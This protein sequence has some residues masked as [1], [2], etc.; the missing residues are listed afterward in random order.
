MT[1]QDLTVL[2]VLMVKNESRIIERCL[3]AALP[4][5]DAV[6]LADTGSSDDTVAVAE[7]TVRAAQKPFH[8]VTNEWQD[9]GTNRTH[10]L[11][12]ARA[13]VRDLGWRLDA[14]YALVLDADMQFRGDPALLKQELRTQRLSGGMVQQRNG[15]LEYANMR[16]VLLSDGWFCEGVTHEYWT[17]GGAQWNVPPAVA[18]I[19]DVGD[20][21]A[22]ADKFERDERLLLAGLAKD[23]GCV[24]YM[25]YLAQTYHCMNRHLDAIHWYEKRIAAGSWVEEVWYSHLMIARTY[26]RLKEPF[27]AEEWVHKGRA[28]QPE[29]VEGLLSLVTHLREDGQ[30]VKAWHYLKLAEA[31]KKPQENRLFLE[32]D[33]YGHK[34][35]YER[36]ILH[37]YVLT[38]KHWEGAL[39]SLKYEGPMEHSVLTNLIFYA[40]EL[41]ST[42]WTRLL[43]PTP[44]GFTSSSVAANDAA[45]LCVRA[46]SYSITDTGA[47]VM[48][49]GLVE[50][51]N[52]S[53]R[54]DCASKSYSEWE[55][56]VPDAAC[57]ERWKRDDMIRGLEDV[58]LCGDAFTATTREFSYC[59][60]NRMVHGAF[61]AMT[62]A[63]VRPPGGETGCEKNWLPLDGG[64]A[65][66]GWHPM[67]VG[68]VRAEGDGPARFEVTATHA[69]PAWF[70][71]LRGS[72]P[73]LRVGDELWALTHI[74]SPRAPRHYLHAWV[75]LEKDTFRPT[76]Y[77]PPFYFKHRG[78]EYCL[79]GLVC[80]DSLQLFTSVWDR[81]SWCC[82]VPVDVV[83]RSL[84]PLA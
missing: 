50:T 55:E 72:M 44:E 27:R 82:E 75:A 13:Y 62:F 18:W 26:L 42:A 70:R 56:V 59:G 68:E 45:R 30:H 60:S 53:A 61:P 37:Y 14:T 40:D 38:D 78:I 11:V 28:L 51:R 80:G 52:F 23:P 73:P 81:E 49:S 21:G 58:R 63:P 9:F 64:R 66:Y 24:R 65:I 4:F 16:I 67:R 43:F 48:P 46:V 76:A 22:K 17:G 54:W 69:T 83:R 34:L 12:A 79:G 36:S 33:A 31:Q 8:S 2:L 7:R 71:H 5:V 20:G 10:S 57:A 19:D 74:V 41:P 15:S 3:S 6:L 29:R 84:R 1:N 35:D 39:H 77:S 47:Y 25:F 32:T